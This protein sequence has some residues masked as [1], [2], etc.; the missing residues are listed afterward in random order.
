[1]VWCGV[2]GDLLHEGMAWHG[3]GVVWCGVGG[4]LLQ[5]EIH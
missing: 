4:G 5:E 3:S 1:M 2:E